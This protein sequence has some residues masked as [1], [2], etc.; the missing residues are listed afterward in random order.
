MHDQHMMSII[1][2]WT[3]D[4]PFCEDVTTCVLDSCWWCC[5]EIYTHH[6]KL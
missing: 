3:Y 4:E 5:V 6:S 1:F 2:W